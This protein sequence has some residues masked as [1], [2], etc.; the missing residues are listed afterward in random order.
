MMTIIINRDTGQKKEMPIQEPQRSFA[1]KDS[2]L[3][4]ITFLNDRSHYLKP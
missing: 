2:I 1:E 3:S 4:Y